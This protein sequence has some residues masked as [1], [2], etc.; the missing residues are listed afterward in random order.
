MENNLS[1]LNQLSLAKRLF[2]RVMYFLGK[3]S[4]YLA[5]KLVWRLRIINQNVIP[6]TGGVIFASNHV[7]Y[8]DPPLVGSAVPRPIHFMAKQ[9]LFDVPVMGWVIRQWNAFPVKRMERDIGAFKT[10]QRLLLSGNCVILFPEGRRQKNG[11][12]GKAKAGV[13]MLASKAKCAVVPVYIHNSGCMKSFK[14]VSV[15]FGDP[16]RPQENDD[17]QSFSDRIMDS[18]KNLKE[19]HII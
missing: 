14:R 1:P 12:L 8:G 11:V 18:I 7:S 2:R 4:Y 16:M 6:K 9:E 5:F 19:K 13:G 10:A 17:Y 3:T 15:C